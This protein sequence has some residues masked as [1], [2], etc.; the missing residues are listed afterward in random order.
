MAYLLDLLLFS[1]GIF[2]GFYL[3]AQKPKWTHYAPNEGK[4]QPRIKVGG[5]K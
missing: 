3:L 2:V 5:E 4:P 1:A